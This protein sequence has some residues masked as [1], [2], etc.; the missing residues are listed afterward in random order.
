MS[1]MRAATVLLLVTTGCSEA[2]LSFFS[3]DAPKKPN[4][5]ATATSLTLMN[6]HQVS[7][8]LTEIFGT[9]Q[10]QS[11][12]LGQKILMRGPSLGGS[13]DVRALVRASN[14]TPVNPEESCAW[15]MEE[16][17]YPA[18]GAPST[19]G[20]GFVSHACELI[21]SDRQA[22]AFAV[23][24]VPGTDWGALEPPGSDQILAL[25]S[26]F[27]PGQVPSEAMLQKLRDISDVV[28]AQPTHRDPEHQ[29]R[30]LLLT[31]CLTGA[32]LVL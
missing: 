21:L 15:G 17:R 16:T 5:P 27:Y 31:I 22:L 9:G 20:A 3:T 7:S 13:C 6:R 10:A 24:Q 19:L 32:W 18:E 8:V 2:S 26:L 1:R 11:L 4:P 12:A 29:Y 25:W 30:A 23:A 14:G 28:A